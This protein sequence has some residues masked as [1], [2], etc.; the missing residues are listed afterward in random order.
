MKTI[1]DLLINAVKEKKGK[2]VLSFLLDQNAN[3]NYAEKKEDSVLQTAII[4][5]DIKTVKF[6]LK[7][8]ADVN[9]QGKYG[10]TPL[11][12]AL[13]EDNL[14]MISILL[15][16]K[17]IDLNIKS[18]NLEKT[19]LH[20]AAEK[21]YLRIVESMLEKNAD[22]NILAEY[23]QTILHFVSQIGNI[24][25]LKLFLSEAV[26][27]KI[28]INAI[29]YFNFTPAHVAIKNDHPE[30]LKILVDHGADLSV[31]F[32]D[33]HKSSLYFALEDGKIEMAKF[34]IDKLDN[35]CP[36]DLK[37]LINDHKNYNTIEKFF[38]WKSMVMSVIP[39]INKSTITEANLEVEE[40]KILQ[41]CIEEFNY[42]K[43]NS[44]KGKSIYSLSE[45]FFASNEKGN[46]NGIKVIGK[47]FDTV[48]E[49]LLETYD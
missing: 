3:I 19:A 45:E 37:K 40:S 8:N 6:L 33:D 10:L 14:E 26:D 4:Q 47:H 36:L 21:G 5:K 28:S 13:E 23:E 11:H 1:K 30:I 42:I 18:D 9:H 31:K 20:I 43:D 41:K 24:D 17:N 46:D 34:I 38:D 27:L 16:Q 32:H 48:E 22:P 12:N 2:E 25:L 29:D 15:Q 7:N 49:T 44:Q 35:I 39:K